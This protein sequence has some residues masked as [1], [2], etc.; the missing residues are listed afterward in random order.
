M[1]AWDLAIVQFTSTAIGSRRGS[2]EKDKGCGLS[3]DM[4]GLEEK[5]RQT[6][7]DR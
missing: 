3:R 5:D 6:I 7:L 2:E 4:A 1:T